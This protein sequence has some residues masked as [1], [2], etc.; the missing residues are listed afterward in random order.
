VHTD[1]ARTD[2]T[3][4]TEPGRRRVA[5]LAPDDRRAALIEATLPLLREHG[6]AVSTR[7][8]ADAAGVA[9]GTIFRAFP[10]KNSLII[11]TAV[12]ATDP[13]LGADALAAIDRSL[14]LR[15]RVRLA[16]EILHRGQD[17]FGRLHLVLR[18]LMI[19]PDSAKVLGEHLNRNRQMITS[20]L[21]DL[22]LAD[23]DR[24]RV[25]P[26]AAARITLS[27]IFMSRGHMFT[28][29]ET[30]TADELVAVLLDGLLRPPP[31]TTE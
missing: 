15:T 23:A 6:M 10:D 13:T 12:R 20:A 7:Q 25:S 14:D 18:E 30:M 27:M 1:T 28:D 11:A 2:G 24:L 26:L 3:A 9:E 21:V 31:P 5:P 16:A 19:D 4:R 22:Y 8:I 17:H 29:D